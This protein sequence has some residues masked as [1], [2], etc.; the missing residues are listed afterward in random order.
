MINAS[1]R[2]LFTSIFVIILYTVLL[3]IYEPHVLDVLSRAGEF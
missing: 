3:E 1:Q 2:I